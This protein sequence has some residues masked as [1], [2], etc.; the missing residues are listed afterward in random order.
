MSQA[1]ALASKPSFSG[2]TVT[3]RFDVGRAASCLAAAHT[4]PGTRSSLGGQLL[5]VGG[6]NTLKLLRVGRGGLSDV[7]PQ[8][9][10]NTQ[11][12]LS[13]RGAAAAPTSFEICDLDFAPAARDNGQTTLAAAT[14]NGIVAIWDIDSQVRF[15]FASCAEQ[16]TKSARECACSR[17]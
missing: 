14:K 15:R 12:G 11:M 4:P 2:R 6:R 8:L 9:N 13:A 1:A 10:P 3:A 7:G 5:A 16:E 17:V